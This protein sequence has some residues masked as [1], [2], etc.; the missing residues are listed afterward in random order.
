[1]GPERGR[2]AAGARGDGDGDGGRRG[3]AGRD[4][5]VTPAP[6][7]ALPLRDS[8]RGGSG[9]CRETRD[10][11]PRMREIPGMRR[12]RDEETP[13]WGDPRDEETTGMRETPSMKDI[14]G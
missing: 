2:A 10:E 5:A 14:P 1:M 13:G 4:S 11:I 8:G 12:P 6:L 9:G 3:R 7:P